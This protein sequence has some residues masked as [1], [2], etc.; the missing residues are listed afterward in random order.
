V[1]P[2]SVDAAHTTATKLPEAAIDTLA[3]ARPFT[4][5]D[6]G[7]AAPNDTTLAA[8]TVNATANWTTRTFFSFI[9]APD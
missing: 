4:L 5:R 3:L 6:T 8:N 2:A 1:T 9:S 7:A